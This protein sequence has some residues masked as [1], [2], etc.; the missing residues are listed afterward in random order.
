LVK[1]VG[2]FTIPELA[3]RL[4]VSTMTIRRDVSLLLSEKALRVVQGGIAIGSGNVQDSV[5]DLDYQL[6]E[7][8]AKM[9]SETA[10]IARK[11]ATLLQPDDI[12]IIDAGST[13]VALAR[14]IP[15]TLKLTVFCFSLN[16]LLEVQKKKNCLIMITGGYF[17]DDTTM[18]ESAEGLQLIGR[19]RATKAFIGASGVSSS[20]G[21]TCTNP[22]QVENKKAALRSSQT[23]ILLVDSSK[24][25]KVQH[26]FFADMKDFD[27]II[28]D[29]G[30]SPDYADL[31]SSMNIDLMVV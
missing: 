12:T 21:I 15:E 23:K 22:Y 13:T 11:A 8:L 25:G 31:I 10:R 2:V 30:I 1:E 29:N 14:E 9:S 3:E 17:H 24:F 16:I 4:S 28:T 26:A 6:D 7:Q 19:I 27:I 5:G 18:F 20:L